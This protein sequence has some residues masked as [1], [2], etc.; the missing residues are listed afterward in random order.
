MTVV[1]IMTMFFIT[2]S[3]RKKREVKSHEA[4]KNR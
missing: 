4:D 2:F 1:T 3:Q